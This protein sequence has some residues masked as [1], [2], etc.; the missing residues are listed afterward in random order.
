MSLIFLVL[1]IALAAAAAA[2][3]AYLWAARSGQF[4]DLE[5]PRHRVLWEDEPAGPGAEPPTSRT[6]E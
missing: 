5:T 4:D 2:V 6:R 1:P 3:L